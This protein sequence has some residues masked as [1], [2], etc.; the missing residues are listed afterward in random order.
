MSAYTRQLSAAARQYESACD[1]CDAD[2]RA[3]A[4]EAAEARA[5]LGLP[6][7]PDAAMEFGGITRSENAVSESLAEV[8][9]LNQVLGPDWADGL[10]F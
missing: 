9:R 3:I 6:P 5:E 10:P 7:Y 2:P 4:A 8:R 1:C